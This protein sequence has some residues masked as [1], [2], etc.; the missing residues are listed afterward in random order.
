MRMRNTDW[1]LFVAWIGGLVVAG[2]C[3]VWLIRSESG[4]QLQQGAEQS[5]LHWANFASRTVPDLDVAFAGG[6]FTAAAREQLLR[7]R[8]AEDVFRFKLFDPAGR[9]ILVSDDLDAAGELKKP[10]VSEG[11][12]H[13][14]ADAARVAIRDQVLAGR[15]ET[16][17][18]VK[19][20]VASSG[21]SPRGGSVITSG[22]GE[23]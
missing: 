12:G 17:R 6:G 10:S 13:D 3:L 9:L 14:S 21:T 8:T 20:S 23:S 19:V 4:R 18:L 2:V 22:L 11:I 16:L 5:A 15:E 1:K 7:L